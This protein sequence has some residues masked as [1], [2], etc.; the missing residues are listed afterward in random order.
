M[1]YYKWVAVD[2]NGIVHRGCGFARTLERITVYLAAQGLNVIVKPTAK[3]RTS[4][5][6][7]DKAQICVD[8]QLLLQAGVLV[9]T[10]FELV[11]QTQKNVLA[12][13]I[14][15]DCAQGL[16]EG[17]ML[18]TLMGYHLELWSQED[19][20]LVSAGEITDNLPKVFGLIARRYEYEREFIQS[21][22][23]ALLMPLCTLLFFCV[24]VLFF[25]I[26]V[27]P[28]FKI[29]L[30]ER[31]GAHNISFVSRMIFGASDLVHSSTFIAIFI[32]AFVSI[33]LLCYVTRHKIARLVGNF[34]GLKTIRFYMIIVR[35]LD[36]CALFLQAGVP[37]AP[38]L[39]KSCS[40]V[41][42]YCKADLMQLYYLVI[43]GMPLSCA[44]NHIP[45]FKQ[46][47][48]IG[49]ISVGENTGELAPSCA[50][51]AQFYRKKLYQ[52]LAII[53]QV[54]QPLILIIM[55]GLIALFVI[56]LYGPL[57]SV[58]TNLSM[59]N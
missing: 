14:L 20:S 22:K 10:V 6:L 18:S 41:P 52:Q 34:P 27:V 28:R 7:P 9:P 45:F 42:E 15:L 58:A 24:L 55:G 8:I 4:I 57:F 5:S 51:A 38:T 44:L 16:Q 11:A 53:S 32:S 47:L 54:V 17:I 35:W 13:D 46:K 56:A 12:K 49:L 39:E 48:L 50:F 59:L 19:V 1:A 21:L 25:L 31:M 3:K 2:S 29:L 26:I 37:L 40:I 23:Q 36:M 30:S 33:F 43:A